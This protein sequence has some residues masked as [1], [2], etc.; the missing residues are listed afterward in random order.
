MEAQ[1]TQNTEIY[2]LKINKNKSLECWNDG[3]V[4]EV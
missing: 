2:K 4:P 3:G 1:D